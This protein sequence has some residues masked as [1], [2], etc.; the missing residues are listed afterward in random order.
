M[1][2]VLYILSATDRLGGATKALMNL[3]DGRKDIVPHFIL[4]DDAGIAEELRQRHIPYSVLDYRMC[5]YP[6]VRS[7]KDCLLFVLRW[8]GR[9]W[10]NAHATRQLVQIAKDWKADIIHTNTSVNDIGYQAAC[11]LHLPHVWHIREYGD[12]HFGYRHYPGERVFR[13]KFRTEQS[14]TICITMDIQRYNHLLGWP[15]S[16][17]IYDGV[18]PCNQAGLSLPK[19]SY[20]LFAGRLEEGKGVEQLLL[21]YAAYSAKVN[22]PVPLWIAGGTQQTGY[23]DKLAGIVEQLQINKHVQ[24]LGWRDDI[25]PL[26]QSALALVVPSR[27]EGFGFVAAEG[28]F[29]GAL[30]IGKNVCGIKEQLDNGFELTKQEIALGYQTQDE[31]VEHLLKVSQTGVEPYIS[32]IKAGQTA[33]KQLYSVESHQ[34]AVYQFYCDIIKQKNK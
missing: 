8:I 32:M 3:I 21:A 15:A 19:K 23:T 16:R 17:V 11:K 5:V 33:A 24:F 25:L 13:K 2:R 14:Y 28:M 20:F 12:L 1:I 29:A 27:A 7:L 9:I 6:P 30:V 10:L 34:R 26:M 22:H 4:P 18:L 31:L